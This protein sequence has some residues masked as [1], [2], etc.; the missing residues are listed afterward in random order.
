[1]GFD[2]TQSIGGWGVGGGGG[3]VIYMTQ[4]RFRIIFIKATFTSSQIWAWLRKEKI[5][6]SDII[7]S[8]GGT[9]SN[10]HVLQSVVQSYKDLAGHDGLPHIITSNLE[11]D[12]IRLPLKHMEEQGT[13]S[14]NC[15]PKSCTDTWSFWLWMQ[16]YNCISKMIGLKLLHIC[17]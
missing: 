1:M 10:N 12:S 6:F 11:H 2:R 8:S 16:H 7:F 9:E 3:V 4:I 17:D 13:A 5:C 15:C 14:E